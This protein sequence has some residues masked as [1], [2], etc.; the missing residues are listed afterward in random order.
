[1]EKGSDRFFCGAEIQVAY[2]NILQNSL[3]VI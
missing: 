2:K 3:L 1:L